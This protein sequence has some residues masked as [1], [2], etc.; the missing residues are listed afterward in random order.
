VTPAP[1]C[2]RKKEP[3]FATSSSS[4]VFELPGR[5][6]DAAAAAARAFDVLEAALFAFGVAELA[7][8][9]EA[10]WLAGELLQAGLAELGD[11]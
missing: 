5:T 9:S 7:D 8:A 6:Q 10:A 1:V 3:A 4:S 11:D 2:V